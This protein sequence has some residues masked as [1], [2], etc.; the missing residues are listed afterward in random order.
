MAP[1]PGRASGPLTVPPGAACALHLP[2]TVTVCLV[3]VPLP[4]LQ[5]EVGDLSRIIIM[6][7]V[8][9]RRG[10][11]VE[12]GG[13]CMEGEELEPRI[14]CSVKSVQYSFSLS[15]ARATKPGS[16]GPG[17]LQV[18]QT[19]SSWPSG[20]DGPSRLGSSVRVQP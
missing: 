7:K 9:E 18:R 11:A 6:D 12:A 15:P 20:G 16:P 8:V 1:R 2:V 17:Y 13:P 19:K 5:L 10:E 14:V 4:V 3:R